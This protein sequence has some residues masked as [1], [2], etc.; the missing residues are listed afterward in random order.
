LPPSRVNAR[1]TTTAAARMTTRAKTKRRRRA[2]LCRFPRSLRVIYRG[3]SGLMSSNADQDVIVSSIGF[4][5]ACPHP[6]LSITFARAGEPR[7]GG[8]YVGATLAWS[9]H[10]GGIR[11]RVFVG[12]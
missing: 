11:S 1:T 6:C 10:E 5:A 9:A 2:R 8:E 7:A 12:G 3:K 4:G